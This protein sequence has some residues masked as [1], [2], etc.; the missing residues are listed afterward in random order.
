[1]KNQILI[2]GGSGFIG[3]NLIK[4]LVNEKNFE[5]TLVSRNFEFPIIFKKK[6]RYIK[7]DLTNSK[8]FLRFKKF[9]FDYVIN[10]SGNINHKDRAD[11][12][13]IHYIACKKIFNYFSNKKIKL[14]IQIGSSLEYGNLKSPH[15]ENLKCKPV[16]HY[17]KSKFL[18]TKYIQKIAKKKKKKYLILRLYQVYGPYQKFDRL[19]PFIIKNSLLDRKF[20]C[21]SGQQLRDF[22]YVNDL[23]N[24]FIKIL[25]TKDIKSGIYNVGFGKAV[26]VKTV[27][28]NIKYKIKKGEPLYGAISMRSDE[29]MKLFPDISKVKKNFKWKPKIS[30]LKGLDHTI[31]YYEK[32]TG[33]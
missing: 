28:K 18:A 20:R 8:D 26:Q 27:I 31:K 23:T 6:V 24:L 25:K 2:L 22:L 30:L 17:G 15:K 4:K 16:S 1:M 7:C 19:I 10:L 5:I 14:F 33:V 11:T 29:I 13:K 9:N 3:Q 21:S 12:K 32:N